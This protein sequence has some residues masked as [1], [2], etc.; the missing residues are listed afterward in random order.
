MCLYSMISINLISF[1]FDLVFDSKSVVFFTKCK[2]QVQKGLDEFLFKLFF[3]R[4]LMDSDGQMWHCTHKHLYI[5]ELT[6]TTN[7]QARFGTR[8]V[9]CLVCLKIVM[10]IR[11]VT[12]HGYFY[13]V[14]QIIL[15]TG[16]E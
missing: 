12:F 4:Y 9:S 6:E 15:A 1:H 13:F 7:G 3:L 11:L 5:M 8:L 14:Q 10:I 16:K 2:S